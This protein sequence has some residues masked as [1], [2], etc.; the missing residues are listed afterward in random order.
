VAYPLALLGHAEAAVVVD[1]P[2]LMPEAVQQVVVAVCKSRPKPD[3][4][5]V[6][7]DAQRML[8]VDYD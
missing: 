8:A 5:A 1:V 4:V 6:L 3:R 2:K 7:V